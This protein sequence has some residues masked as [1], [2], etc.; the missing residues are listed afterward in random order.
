M[1]ELAQTPEG[2]VADAVRGNWV[3]T[4]APEWTRPYLRLSRADRPIGTWLLL[5][6]CL[7]GGLL[8]AAS[9]SGGDVVVDASDDLT[10]GTSSLLTSQVRLD[11][12]VDQLIDIR[13]VAPQKVFRKQ[14]VDGLVHRRGGHSRGGQKLL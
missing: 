9:G 6:P 2:Q 3:D 5:I 11:Q 12:R 1:A 8:S 14:H 13:L 4:R 10:R 7:W